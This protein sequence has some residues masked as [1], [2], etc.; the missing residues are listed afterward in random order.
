M[1]QKSIRE[2]IKGMDKSTVLIP[3]I[4]RRFVWNKN[5]IELFMD[6]LINNYPCP[7]VLSWNIT[8]KEYAEKVSGG[9]LNKCDLFKF[10]SAFLED[11]PTIKSEKAKLA[12]EDKDNKL[13][14]I[15]DGQQRLTSL[16]IAFSGTF[17]K[18]SLSVNSKNPENKY[19][20]YL[21]LSERNDK[22]N[23]QFL[24]INSDID[25]KQDFFKV[26]ELPNIIA[27]C[28]NESKELEAL[29]N[30]FIENNIDIEGKER[31]TKL[32]KLFTSKDIIQKM[33][34]DKNKDFNDVIDIFIRLNNGGTPLDSWELIYSRL[35]AKWEGGKE[36]ID[37]VSEKFTVEANTGNKFDRGFIIS[38]SIYLVATDSLIR[39]DKII[40]SNEQTFDIVEKIR[41]NW[42]DIK[43]VFD[44]TSN[45]LCKFYKHIKI[46]SFYP[47]LP[48]MYYIYKDNKNYY[49]Y[50]KDTVEMKE[51]RKNVRDFLF[52][53]FVKNVFSNG[54]YTILAQAKNE[55]DKWFSNKNDD[56]KFT[57]LK[58]YNSEFIK[59]RGTERFCLTDENI[60]NILDKLS[61]NNMT[62]IVL[63]NLN[64]YQ[65]VVGKETVSLHQ[66]HIFAQTLFTKWKF[67]K[68]YI[69]DQEVISDIEK[70]KL[71]EKRQEWSILKDKL[72]NLQLLTQNENQSKKDKSIEEW[73]AEN[74]EHKVQ[75]SETHSDKNGISVIDGV[76][77]D[78]KVKSF[79]D[80]FNNRKLNIM[81]E[82]KERFSFENSNQSDA[83]NKGE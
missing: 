3:H 72:P 67:E 46:P 32:Y 14:I 26:S 74:S 43:K 63:A 10:N 4:Q 61:K 42:N 82:L 19:Y 6:S 24:F 45:L 68:N 9:H 69:E 70:N 58:F 5:D 49:H 34:I 21:S 79:N 54:P 16:L 17:T 78:W 47:L 65:D 56:K 1:E 2:W 37:K 55:I 60:S 62:L 57:V 48:I 23:K 13:D 31:I 81:N 38:S 51:F 52:I 50:F 15:F 29:N 41:N 11:N 80:F 59:I 7:P 27:S 18:K 53:S 71:E 83:N 44:V 36:E 77:E 8:A 39:P 66:D 33:N 22:K 35:I 76:W 12:F 75:Y 28:E 64:E 40:E 25:K 30:Y 73:L 20:L